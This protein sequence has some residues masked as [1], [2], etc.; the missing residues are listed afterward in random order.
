MNDEG[1]N[2]LLVFEG[3]LCV[4]NTFMSKKTMILLVNA[5]PSRAP[6]RSWLC[7]YC[8]CEAF[9]SGNPLLLGRIHNFSLS[10]PDDSDPAPN[11]G[12]I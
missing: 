11:V 9:V 4:E 2:R 8:R 1:C 5:P 6:S 7:H 3:C 10:F 12:E